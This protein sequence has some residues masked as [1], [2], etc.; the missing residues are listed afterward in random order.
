M[1]SPGHRGE[2]H[3]LP[4]ST[5]LGVMVLLDSRVP[6][7]VIPTAARVHRVPLGPAFQSPVVDTQRP[8]VLVLADCGGACAVQNVVDACV[9]ALVWFAWGHSFARGENGAAPNA[10]IGG[11]VSGAARSDSSERSAGR[12]AESW[13]AFCRNRSITRAPFRRGSLQSCGL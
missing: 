1:N 4:F 8:A 11:T 2:E 10:F 13:A 7:L 6:G 12:T 5:F 3:V 9:G